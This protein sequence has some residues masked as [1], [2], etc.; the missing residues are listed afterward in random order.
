MPDIRL[1]T[2]GV[3]FTEGPLWTSDGRLLVTSVSRGQVLELD[4]RT[5]TVVRRVE[6]GGGPNGLAEDEH[7][8]VWVAQ[9]GGSVRRSSSHRPA[10]A[11]LQ[12][13][14][15]GTVLDALTTGVRAP[16]DLVRGPDGRI[17]FTDP[18]SPH[19]EGPGQL[20][21]YDPRDGRLEVMADGIGFPNGLAFDLDGTRL[22]VAATRERRLLGYT[23]DGASLRFDGVLAALPGGPDGLAFDS[24]GRL[25]AALPD[26]D[27]IAVLD[28]DG[29]PRAPI[30]FPDGTFPTNLCFAGPAR[31]TLV[32][33]AAKGGRVLALDGVATGPRHLVPSPTTAR[34]HPA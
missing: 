7:G 3:G 11:G 10:A 19:E 13:L 21:A 31:D 16:N 12:T 32:V 4:H 22:I 25:Y 18:G 30:R 2:S 33:T 23:W 6:T 26:A 34:T 28:A 24:D 15:G 8:R 14:L 17:W 9:N 29:T 20:F 1:L 27:R 5:G